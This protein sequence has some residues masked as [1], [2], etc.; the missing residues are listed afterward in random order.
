M[1]SIEPVGVPAVVLTIVLEVVV[2]RVEVVCIIE[3][4]I[5]APASMDVTEIKA[6]LVAG[7]DVLE[8]G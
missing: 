7:G 5:G 8:G 6:V 1:D 2:D 4:I 3:V